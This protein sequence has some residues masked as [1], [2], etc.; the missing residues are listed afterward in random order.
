MD[1]PT[2]KVEKP[3]AFKK[4]AEAVGLTPEQLKA[5]AVKIIQ[6]KRKAEQ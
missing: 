5:V 6:D 1:K 2:V 4:V 3:D